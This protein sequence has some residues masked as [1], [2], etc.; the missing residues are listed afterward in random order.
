MALP[1]LAAQLYTVRQ[2]VQTEQGLAESLKKIRQIGYTAVQV[3]GIGPID[4]ETV[5]RI[6]DENRLTICITHINYEQLWKNTEEVIRQHQLWD[7]KH[8]AI[9]SLPMAY[10]NDE[11]GYRRFAEEANGVGEQLAQAGLT[12]SYHNHSF[13][14]VRFGGKPALEILFE[15]SD[16]RYLMAEIDTYW[17]QHGGAN[18]AAWVR[19]MK[20]RMPVVH[21]KDMAV[22]P[23]GWNVQQMMAEVGEGNLDWPDILAA[24]EEAG[25]EWAAVE[26]DICQRDPFESL[27]MSYHNLRAMGL[28]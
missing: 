26:Q 22:V 6:A 11:A 8:V 23:D 13:E 20:N 28:Q 2:F 24:C 15:A 1:T 14:F 21:L 3:S 16:P 12:F 7:C 10:R 25:V 17:V 18:P 27:A 4:H 5:K 9:G 19:K